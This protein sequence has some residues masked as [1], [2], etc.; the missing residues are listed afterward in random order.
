MDLRDYPHL[1]PPLDQ[2]PFVMSGQTVVASTGAFTVVSVPEVSVSSNHDGWLRLLGVRLSVYDF[3]DAFW[4]LALNGNGIRDWAKVYSP[5]PAP[6]TPA[7]VII[8]LE[9]NQA[10]SFEV[11][12]GTGGPIQATFWMRGH[13]VKVR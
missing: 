3:N 2:I 7:D 9:P 13:Y 8:R 10:L 4:R 1:F 12:N 6:E 5:G 11:W